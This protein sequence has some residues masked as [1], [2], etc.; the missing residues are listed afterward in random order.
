M[1]VAAGFH[2]ECNQWTS[3][4]SRWTVVGEFCEN[5]SRWNIFQFRFAQTLWKFPLLPDEVAV[6]LNRRAFPKIKSMVNQLR[7]TAHGHPAC[8][9]KNHFDER[10]KNWREKAFHSAREELAVFLFSRRSP[11]TSEKSHDKL[12]INYCW[13][14]RK[15]GK[16]NRWK[17]HQL[18][19]HTWI[20]QA[21]TCCHWASTWGGAHTA[22]G[23]QS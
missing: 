20:I 5:L 7:N 22:W 9:M 14:M 16:K 13:A 15:S 23:G 10:D 12:W 17:R 4:W 11:K 18:C 3:K 1:W 19:E 6:A 2:R 8:D 21:E